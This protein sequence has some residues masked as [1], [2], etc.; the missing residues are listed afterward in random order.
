[1]IAAVLFA[2]LVVVGVSPLTTAQA[3]SPYVIDSTADSPD[4]NLDDGVCAS[5]AGECTLRAALQ[6]A[7]ADGVDAT[8][9]LDPILLASVPTFAPSTELSVVVPSS[10]TITLQGAA[11]NIGRP[12]I[13]GGG[14]HRVFNVSGSGVFSL[15]GFEITDGQGSI[16]NDAGDLQIVPTSPTGYRPYGGSGNPTD[17]Y[18][19]P[20]S[21]L[22]GIS[23]R[24]N[25]VRNDDAACLAPA[26]QGA[27]L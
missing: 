3:A 19:G 17:A 25:D 2:G 4:D 15:A 24:V 16:I 12:V 18:C 23:V 27:L 5:D 20:S 1:M 7:V 26:E 6:Q 10:V 11:T 13:S 21:A 14:T 8:I 9:T 22:T